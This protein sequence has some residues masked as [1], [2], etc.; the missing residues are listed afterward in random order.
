MFILLQSL[1]ATFH[2][3]NCSDAPIDPDEERDAVEIIT[4]RGFKAETHY[5]ITK[6]GY[7]LGIHR[8]INPELSQFNKTLKPVLLQHGL[9]GSST[10]WLINSPFLNASTDKLTDNEGRVGNNLGFVL[11]QLG[12]DVWLS[13]SRGNIYST[14]HTQL[15]TGEKKFW[16]FTFDEM[17]AYDLPAIIQYI[18]KTTNQSS[19]GYIGHS[20]GTAIM[21]ALLSS[22]PEYSQIINPFIALAPIAYV[23]GI[24]SPIRYFTEFS[25]ALR[26]IGGEFLP[27]D[28][29]MTHLAE[30][31]CDN[32]VKFICANLLYLFSGYD[33]DQLN[34]TRLGVYF[35][36]TPSGTSSWNI[37]HFAQLV[38]SKTFSKFDF[39]RTDNQ[40][41]YG[42]K[43]PPEYRLEAITSTKIALIYSANDWLA[44]I[45][46]VI[47]LKQQLKVP[48]LSEYM[49]PYKKWCH[50][51]YIFGLDAGLY[52]YPKSSLG[53]IGG[54]FLPSDKLMTHLAEE[55]CDNE[56]KFICANLLYLFSGYDRDQLNMTRLGVY[57]TH[58]PSGTS[59][60]NIA[61]F[62]QLIKSKTF[63]KFDFG[64]TDNQIIYGQKTPPE[65]SDLR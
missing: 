32:E 51:D 28:K 8:I 42:Q 25:S 53:F 39:G 14:N 9:L 57:F 33:R 12:Y 52:V 41:I 61:H 18:L 7:I 50:T 2:H 46:D 45:D 59:S 64:R 10:D 40:I 21:F 65:L 30:E 13:N 37:A 55:F 15:K 4:S 36:H 49:V 22:K 5:V 3:L 19:I 35:T 56:V 60:W 47:Q 16:R 63:S 62:A 24:K 38:K 11:S 1:C 27:S 48:L 44:D 29:L 43:T 34:M 31:F 26:F 58:T 20:Q 6:D 17:S 54:E 23:A